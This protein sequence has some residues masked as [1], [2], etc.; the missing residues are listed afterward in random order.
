MLGADHKVQ[1]S[2]EASKRIFNIFDI[3]KN[4]RIELDEIKT[5]CKSL[6]LHP[7]LKELKLM[8]NEISDSDNFTIT[9]E[10]FRAMRVVNKICDLNVLAEFKKFD[11]HRLHRG[12]ITRDCLFKVFAAE[13][14]ENEELDLRVDEFMRH[15]LDRDGMITFKELYES[16]MK[17][18]P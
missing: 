1:E 13:G 4:G 17:R 3:N 6:M 16:M 8:V 7:T 10:Q 12:I 11:V 18:I 2:I 15:D 5:V 9:F 14:F